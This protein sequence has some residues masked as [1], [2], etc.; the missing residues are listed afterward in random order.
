MQ[1]CI[2]SMGPRLFT[3]FRR[4]WACLRLASRWLRMALSC[5]TSDTALRSAGPLHHSPPLLQRLA[6]LLRLVLGLALERQCSLQTTPWLPYA[7]GRMRT[8]WFLKLL[9][10]STGGD[11]QNLGQKDIWEMRALM[12]CRRPCGTLACTRL[13]AYPGLDDLL[14]GQC[15]LDQSAATAL[16]Q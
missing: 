2:I 15:S 14:L 16:H 6:G 13:G 11:R 1:S 4:C 7:L 9:G 10:S 8:A 3:S 5:C 12:A